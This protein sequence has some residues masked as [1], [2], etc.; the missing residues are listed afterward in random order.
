MGRIEQVVDALI[1][2]I[3]SSINA[4]GFTTPTQV[5]MGWPVATELVEIVSQVQPQVSIYPLAGGR[6]INPRGIHISRPA[7]GST[8]LNYTLAS[9]VLTFTGNV[10]GGLNVAIGVGHKTKGFQ[11]VE[12]TT[13]SSDTLT[14][15]A[16]AITTK[17]N[18][19]G[20]PLSAT[21]SGAAITFTNAT[22][23][24]PRIGTTGTITNVVMAWEQMIQVSVWAPNAAMRA[25]LTDIIISNVGTQVNPWLDL[26][27]TTGVYLKLTAAPR[28]TD[29]S[30]SD[31]NLYESHTRYLAQY[32]I[33][34][35]VP[36]AQVVQISE[37][38]Q[39]PNAS[40]FTVGG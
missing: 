36:A 29:E 35:V 13:S 24:S 11:I 38:F 19:I 5:S 1:T 3:T 16:T 31:Y 23:I 14:T 10:T 12:Y 20:T 27:D 39:L 15:L 22:S 8:S 40:S 9:N 32:E 30:Q 7:I 6:S 37:T 4:A 26:G 18:A 2:S 33:L 17:L 28:Y 25:A 21:S 34:N